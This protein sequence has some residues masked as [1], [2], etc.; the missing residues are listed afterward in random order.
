MEVAIRRID[1]ELPL[2]D[3]KTAGAVAMDLSARE[4][5]TIAPGE[6]GVAHLNVTLKLPKGHFALMAAR[7]S[8]WKRGLRLA[9]GIGLFDEDYAGDAD[10]YRAALHNFTKEPVTV[11][12]GERIVQ[13]MVLP[14]DRVTW[15]EVDTHDMPDRGGYGTTGT[16]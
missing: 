1:K 6:V 11:E 16:I 7:S 10:E 4:E 13:L 14:H 12:R 3:Y 9:N 15:N 8:L 5:L 2:P